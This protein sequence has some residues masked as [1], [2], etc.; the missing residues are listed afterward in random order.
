ML[1]VVIIGAGVTGCCIA[2]ELSRYDAK[3]T[4]IE[5]GDDVASGTSKA[6]SGVIHS[7]FDAKPGTLMAKLNVEG[8]RLMWERA[9]ELDFPVKKNGALVVCTNEG[10]RGKLDVLLD[11]AHQNGVP[12]VRIMEREEVMAMEPNLTDATVAALYAPTGGVIC[13]F[14]LAI[15][16]GENANVNGVDFQFETEALSIVPMEGGYRIKTNKGTLETKT[17]VSGH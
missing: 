13:P 1:D 3:I 9:K 14:N 16:M 4:V 17:V 10:E 2:R 15:A 8:N 7:G 11:Q 5:K 12:G 6:N